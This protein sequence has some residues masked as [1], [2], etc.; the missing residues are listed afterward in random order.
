MVL[1]WLSGFKKIQHKKLGGEWWE[2]LVE[3]LQG[4]EWRH[5][6]DQNIMYLYE[7]LKKQYKII[8]KCILTWD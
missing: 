2:G 3:E 5:R 1:S 4:T 7:I 8:V 6:L